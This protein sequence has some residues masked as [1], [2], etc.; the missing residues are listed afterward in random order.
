MDAQKHVSR[1]N[2]RVNVTFDFTGREVIEENPINDFDEFDDQFEVI[3]ELM[4]FSESESPN[5][6]PDI[7][8]DRP[9]VRVLLIKFYTY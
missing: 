5:V 7:E 4:S 3:S 9:I 1:L 8:F 2:R 6:C